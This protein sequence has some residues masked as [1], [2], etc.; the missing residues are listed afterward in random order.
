M[1]EV[2]MRATLQERAGFLDINGHQSYYIE[3]DSD[4]RDGG[5][6][7]GNDSK[8]LLPGLVLCKVTTGGLYKEYANAASDGTQLEQNCVI[9]LEPINDIST[10]DQRAHV[11][12]NG[13]VRAAQLRW[14]T[15]ADKTAF[16]F[17]KASF[18][19]I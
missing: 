19:A 17:G 13:V 16:E 11:A 6:A 18:A 14:K 7:G 1:N 9:L 4:A 8:E 3:I 15:A 10:G 5:T 2:G 12:P